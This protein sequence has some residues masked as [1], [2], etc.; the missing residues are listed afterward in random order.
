MEFGKK[1]LLVFSEL[2][3]PA[4]LNGISIRYAPIIAALGR[5]HEVHVAVIVRPN[6]TRYPEGLEDI[7]ESVEV[8]RRGRVHPS[9]VQ[10]LSTRVTKCFSNDVPY[11]LYSYDNAEIERF[12]R[13][14]E[15]ARSFDSIVWVGSMHLE[16]GIKV[17]GGERI[18]HDAIDSLYHGHLRKR[19]RSVFHPIDSARI[20][21][22]ERHL[23]R[24]TAGT[25][26]VSKIDAELFAGDA[27]L[28]RKVSVF[29]N[30]V[31]LG[32]FAGIREP[33]ANDGVLTLGFLGHMGYQPNIE[34]ALRLARIYAAVR[35]RDSA[36]RLLILGRD[37]APEIR[38]LA[39]KEGVE[40]TGAVDDIWEYIAK[41]DI[42]VFPMVSGAG[43]QNKVLEAMYGGKAVVC[44]A[45][46]NSGIGAMD[47][48]HLLIRKTDEEFVAAIL[49]LKRSSEMR[50]RIA[51]S[52]AAFVS[53]KYSWGNIIPLVEQF[54][55][56]A[57]P[58]AVAQR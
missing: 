27:A 45:L 54:W 35:A 58:A 56:S 23:I 50:Q 9:L 53:E 43:Q 38:A 37:P 4:R 33:A 6:E 14:L 12:L 24:A 25:S 40:V 39:A 44:N 41:V 20:A 29:P 8:F 55:L 28:M 3:Y 42:F 34:A 26:F 48:A 51:Q 22:W 52:G 31:F 21:A 47:N 49:E 17:F 36:F 16:I 2:P 10:R 11:P 46:A 19:Q 57:K 7:C 1:I 32:D 30:G 5:R 18:V 13:T 15:Q